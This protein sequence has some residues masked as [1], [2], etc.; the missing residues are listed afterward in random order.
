Q[1]A[2]CRAA[3]I[4]VVP[5]LERSRPDDVSPGREQLVQDALEGAGGEPYGARVRLDRRPDGHPSFRGQSD[6]SPVRA[7]V[8]AVAVDGAPHRIHRTEEGPASLR[9]RLGAEA[10]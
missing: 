2:R 1:P 4:P 10:P 3:P 8:V 5:W 7:S 6:E 9:I